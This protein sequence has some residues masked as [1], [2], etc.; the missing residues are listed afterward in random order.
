MF[1]LDS[2]VLLIIA[3]VAVATGALAYGLLYSRIEVEKKTES[4]ISRVKSAETDLA[5]IKAARDR[6]LARMVEDGVVSADDAAQARAV[7][8]QRQRKPMP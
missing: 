2:S 5:K 8:V 3:L 7:P 1:G 6:V 4:R